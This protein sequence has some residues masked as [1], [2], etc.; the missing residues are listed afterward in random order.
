LAALEGVAFF[1]VD[2]EDPH[3][4]LLGGNLLDQ[5]LGWRLLLAC[6]DADRTFDP[7]AGCALDVVEHLAAATA[8]AAD[9]VAMAVR[10]HES[11][12]VAR[13]H[14]AV[15]DEHHALEPEALL[16]I[17]ED[18]G[19]RFGVAPIA[20]KDVV[21]DRPAVDHDQAD[22]NLPVARL[23]VTAVA[24][25]PEPRWPLTFEIGRGQIVEYHVDAQ[26]EQIAQLHK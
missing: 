2:N 17:V 19:D 20:L 26:R 7:R 11:E 4:G 13:H 12:V 18:L 1:G 6:G 10:A 14:A 24:V 15:A 5:G 25:R 23:V 3:A 22:Q 8:V 21:S 9:D 16:K